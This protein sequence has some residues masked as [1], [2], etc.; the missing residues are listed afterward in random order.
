MD[1]NEPIPTFPLKRPALAFT[2]AEV[3]VCLAI[4]SLIFCGVITA[5]V[6]S[7]YRAEWSG[8]SLAA[9]A[10]SIQQLEQAKAA[11]WDNT[12]CQITNLNLTAWSCSNNVWTGYTTNTL[13]LPV[14]G[15]NCLYATNFVTVSLI[16]NAFNTQITYYMVR[17]DTVWPFAWNKGGNRLYTNTIADLFAP[18]MP[19][20]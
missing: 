3:V 18:D 15:T 11:V 1:A 10:Y 9:Q 5:Y 13:D 6:Q 17:V 2:L 19:S 12:K 8:L 4:A 7:L 14:S 20:L 16:S